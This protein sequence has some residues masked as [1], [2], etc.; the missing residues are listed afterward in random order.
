MSIEKLNFATTANIGSEW[1]INEDL[2]LA[3]FSVFASNSVLSD[4]STDI[5]SDPYSVMNTLTSL[6]V[7]V[8]SSLLV[9]EKIK[10]A[11]NALFDVP[12]KRKDQKSILFGWIKIEPV[13]C[14]S[15][16]K[17]FESP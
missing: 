17:N 4:T 5:G 2:D 10:G 8:K 15:S 16:E 3:Y 7:P 13:A 14:E 12:A 6:R 1:F 9:H 11:H